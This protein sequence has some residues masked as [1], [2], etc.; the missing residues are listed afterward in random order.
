MNCNQHEGRLLNSLDCQMLT[1]TVRRHPFV[2]MREQ[3]VTN[4]ARVICDGNQEPLQ[5]A[6]MLAF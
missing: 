6:W 2:T 5:L 3:L 1:I 4:W